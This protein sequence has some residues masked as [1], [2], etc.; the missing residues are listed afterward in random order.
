MT[1]SKIPFHI[2]KALSGGSPEEALTDYRQTEP[3]TMVVSGVT[4]SYRTPANRATGNDVFRRYQDGALDISYAKDKV[5]DMIHAV[6]DGHSIT[7]VEKCILTCCF[8]EVFYFV[9]PDVAANLMR[10]NLRITP[11]EMVAIAMAVAAHLSEEANYNA[12]MGGG[13]VPGRGTS[14]A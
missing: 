8:P 4:S 12:G 6:K 9:D 10:I 14:R 13:S 5:V 7:E 3:A 2:Q 11:Q 1:D